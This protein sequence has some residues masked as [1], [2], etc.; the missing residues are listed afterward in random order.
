MSLPRLVVSAERC[1]RGCQAPLCIGRGKKPS[2]PGRSHRPRYGA[3]SCRLEQ[4]QRR[5]AAGRWVSDWV[6]SGLE[7]RVTV[8]KPREPR[9]TAG[10]PAGARGY[11]L[12]PGLVVLF[13][14][15]V[16]RRVDDVLKVSGIGAVAVRACMSVY[17]MSF[18]LLLILIKLASYHNLYKCCV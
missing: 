4:F 11:R 10:R 15:S 17:V 14:S 3:I 8:I 5:S 18:I 6:V 9:E 13:T 16:C 12:Q 2:S 1:S 7:Y